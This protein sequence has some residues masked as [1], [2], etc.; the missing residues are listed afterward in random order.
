MYASTVAPDEED[1]IDDLDDDASVLGGGF[2]GYPESGDSTK[3]VAL[4]SQ[5]NAAAAV[6]TP[7]NLDNKG[8]PDNSGGSSCPMALQ[9]KVSMATNPPIRRNVSLMFGAHVT[10]GD[11][12][13]PAPPE[14]VWVKMVDQLS[15]LVPFS[16]YHKRLG[17]YI[18]GH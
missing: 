12:I 8:A 4:V 3:E 11:V 6:F 15:G 9:N 5:M 10:G 16:G 2:G 7:A 13:R 17:V 18:G 1:L 14:P